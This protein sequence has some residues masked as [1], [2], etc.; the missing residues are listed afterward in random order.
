MR[1]ELDHPMAIEPSLAKQRLRRSLAKLQ[2]ALICT[3]NL[4]NSAQLLGRLGQL[5]QLTYLRH[6][7]QR[8]AIQACE[9]GNN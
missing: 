3:H 7:R 6:V 2:I 5:G 8:A 1:G 9:R 4:G